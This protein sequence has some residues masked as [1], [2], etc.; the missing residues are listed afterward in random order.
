MRRSRLGQQVAAGQLQLHEHPGV[1]ARQRVLQP[2]QV[3]LQRLALVPAQLALAGH[4]GRLV[5]QREDVEAERAHGELGALVRHLGG[6]A[7]HGERGWGER[8]SGG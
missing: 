6:G 8:R 5:A 7:D 4:P 1:G 2:A 3:L